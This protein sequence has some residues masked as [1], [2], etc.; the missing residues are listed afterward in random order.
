MSALTSWSTASR[1]AAKP[2]NRGAPRP[3]IRLR[4]YERLVVHARIEVVEARHGTARGRSG[5]SCE[6]GRWARES[7]EMEG[8]FAY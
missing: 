6:G 3:A 8:G 2:I 4:Q 5:R 7:R 1:C